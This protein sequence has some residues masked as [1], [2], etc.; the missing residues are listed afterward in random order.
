MRYTKSLIILAYLF[1]ASSALAGDVKEADLAG[2]WY[3]ASKPELTKLLQGYLDAAD[4]EKFEGRPFAV[5]V[6]HAGYVFSGSV[7]AFGYKAVEDRPVRTVILIGFTHRNPFKG[8]SVYGRGSF[9]T[10]L[11]DI[12]VDEQLARDIS[13]QSQRISYRPEAFNNE[14]SIEMQV[15]FIQMTFKG[16]RIVPIAFGGMEYEDAAALADALVKTLRG[17][18]DYIVIASTDLSHYHPYS[19]ADIID[20][21]LL[22][23]LKGMDA[24]N[25]YYEA[26]LGICE[27]CGLMPVTSTILAAK[28]LGF[29]KINI[30]K[31]ANS[32]D[33]SGRKDNV[34]GYVSAVIYKSAVHSPQSIVK[35]E[36]EKASKVDEK[37]GEAMLNATQR[38]RLLQIARESITDYVKSGKRRSFSEKDPLLNKDLGAFVTL[39]EKGQLRGCI[40]NMVGRGPLYQTIADMAIEAATADPRFPKLSPAEIDK[41]DIEVSV[42][43]PLKK[44]SGPDEIKIPGHGV[45]VRRGFASG[46]YL[47]QVALETGWTKEEFLTSLCGQKAGMDP[48]AWKDPATDMY[49]FEAEVFG[50]KGGGK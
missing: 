37:K 45:I 40:G 39:H 7:A 2:T 18:D 9:R 1:I 15:P 11:G 49:T 32:G 29:D 36:A 28:R 3:P 35:K 25:L 31:Y 6:P 21:H 13:A 50:E 47:P 5:I 17:R 26:R 14:N 33:T 30:L 48:Y 43:T 23:V 12:A 8:I 4:P 42:L 44:V 20:K 46:V 22:N 16:A 38:E 27:L 10:P 24:N 34:V 41:I 19:E